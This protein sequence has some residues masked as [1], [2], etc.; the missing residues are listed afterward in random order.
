MTRD[1]MD[2]DTVVLRAVEAEIGSDRFEV[3]F[4]ARVGLQLCG[5]CLD[6]SAPTRFLAEQLESMFH[7][8]LHTAA[9]KLAG[10]GAHVAF[11][12]QPSR[13]QGASAEASGNAPTTRRAEGSRSAPEASPRGAGAATPADRKIARRRRFASLDSFI[14]GPCNQTAWS[15]LQ[16]VCHD[17]GCF[18]PLVIWGPPGTGKSHLLEGVWGRLRR[19]GSCRVLYLTAEQFTSMYVET[20][21]ADRG[22]PSFRQKYRTVDV[23]LVDDVQFFAKKRAT[24]VEFQ[25][26]LDALQRAGKQVVLTADRPPHEL[27]GIG[28]ELVARLSGGLVCGLS[29]PDEPT[30]VGILQRFVRE[31]EQSGRIKPGR[32][33]EAGLRA[34]ARLIPGDGR[35]L[36]GALYQVA[37][38]SANRSTPLTAPAVERLLAPL[39]STLRR[40]V[41]LVDIE[42]AVCEVFGVK[43]QS[44]HSH[45]RTKQIAQPRM[46]AMWLARKYTPAVY[47]EIGE[48]FGRRSHATV[49]AATKTVAQWVDQDA[50]I[51]L[52]GGECSVHEAIERVE[53]RLRRA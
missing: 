10:E 40:P 13:L 17:P 26:T 29:L 35:Q 9:R 36:R 23:L 21:R 11:Q 4:G 14:V 20:I 49:I 16:T 28:N 15:S 46:L 6:V 34:I 37:A 42:R 38:A 47:A 33:S 52:F 5:T 3:W 12:V 44:L 8:E 7:R 48:Y 18:S 24:V 25:H 32:L 53:A 22:L 45:K 31:M 19:D 43:A 1:E 30:R 51:T 41:E 27:E 39:A 50:T 2:V